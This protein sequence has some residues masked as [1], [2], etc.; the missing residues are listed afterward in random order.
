MVFQDEE[1][2]GASASKPVPSVL[3]LPIHLQVHITFVEIFKA[4]YF[5]I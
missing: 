5:P 4:L 3:K 1:D 2:E